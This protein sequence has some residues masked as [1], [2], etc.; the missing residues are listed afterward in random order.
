MKP[1]IQIAFMAG[2]LR[3]TPRLERW[4]LREA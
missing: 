1:V 2:F 3:L 4:F